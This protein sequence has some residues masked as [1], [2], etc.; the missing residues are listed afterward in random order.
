[1]QVKPAPAAS[2]SSGMSGESSSEERAGDVVMTGT[3]VTPVPVSAGDSVKADFGEFGAL[4][5]GFT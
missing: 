3:R 2:I 4:E 1:M 5:V